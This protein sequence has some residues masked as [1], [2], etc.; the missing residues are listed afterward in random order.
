MQDYFDVQLQAE[1]ARRDRD[2]AQA[3]EAWDSDR[4][5]LADMVT[6]WGYQQVQDALWAHKPPTQYDD[7]WDHIRPEYA[8]EV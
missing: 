2:D 5:V 1:Q 3:Q 7:S 6:Q 4:A 8:N